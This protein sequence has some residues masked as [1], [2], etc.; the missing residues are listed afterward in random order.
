MERIP[1]IAVCDDDI[2]VHN[3]IYDLLFEYS[4]QHP[5]EQMLFAAF[6][7]G[8]ALLEC[9]EEL[10][11]LFLDIELGEESGIDLVPKIK[12]K[13][14]DIL[15]IFISSHTK[16]F[17]FSHRLHVFQFL[18]KP[19]DTVIFFEEL[20]RFYAQY[21]RSRDLY[22][23]SY[24]GEEISFPICEI[25]YMESYLRY[26]KIYH[27]K[28]GLYEIAGQISKEEQRLKDYGFMRCHHGFLVNPRYIGSIK[29]QTI[30]LLIPDYV[31]NDIPQEIPVSRNKLQHI[32]QQYLKW[33]QEQKG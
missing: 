32:K 28:T 25:V 4:K 16:Y 9:K 20:E 19:F 29:G 11:L 6:D 14:P 21:H 15:I 7:N 13:Y 18:T 30:H 33:L 31:R 22:T 26:L 17:V 8:A 2:A 3:Q 12:E 23:I 27:S 10:D 24:K 5:E 1:K